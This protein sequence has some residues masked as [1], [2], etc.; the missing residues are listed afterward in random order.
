MRIL[1][2]CILARGLRPL[3]VHTLG[4][5]SEFGTH[6]GHALGALMLPAHV[7]AF[8]QSLP[9]KTLTRPGWM[10]ARN[11]EGGPATPSSL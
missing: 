8:S 6:P 3:G 5:H 4:S 9:C 1:G 7:S 2:V 10:G 11:L